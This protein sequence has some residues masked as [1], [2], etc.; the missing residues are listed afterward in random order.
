MIIS[1]FALSLNLLS[2]Y[3]TFAQ[4]TI[5]WRSDYKLKWG[6]FQGKPVM[7]SK[8]KAIT[9]A[10]VKGSLSYN[11]SSFSVIV[12]CSFDK[13]KSWTNSCDSLGLAHE[14]GHFDIAEVF[15]RKLRRTLK[16]YVF[17]PKTIETNYK[18]VFSEMKTERKAFND[19][20]DT[21][22]NFSRNRSK[23]IYWNKKILAELKKLEAYAQ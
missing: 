1:G 15:A 16:L 4:D 23:Q 9:V 13:N 12:T 3:N 5:N 2:F 17:S 10:D 6:D 20:Y 22:T 7:A 19:L 18:R 21:Q 11:S 14:Q 8:Y